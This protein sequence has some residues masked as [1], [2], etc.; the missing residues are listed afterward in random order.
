VHSVSGD[1]DGATAAR[2]RDV[3]MASI[4]FAGYWRRFEKQDP[5][6]LSIDLTAALEL[7]INIRIGAA[8]T[9]IDFCQLQ[10]FEAKDT[11]ADLEAPEDCWEV[12]DLN[13]EL[14]EFVRNPADELAIHQ[15]ERAPSTT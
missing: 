5:R 4:L 15:L 9:F 6:P 10:P 12:G 14:M 7:N 13:A 2:G 11:F 3:T 1:G 8:R